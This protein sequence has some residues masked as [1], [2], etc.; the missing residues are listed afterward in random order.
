MDIYTSLI[1]SLSELRNFLSSLPDDKSLYLDLE[2]SN[3]GRHGSISLLTV[4]V[5]P[6]NQV[7]LI[8]LLTLGS[9]AFTTSSAGGATLKSILGDPEVPKYFWDLRNDADA[10]WSLFNV[11]LANVTD[12]QLLENASRGSRDNT[13]LSGLDTAVRLDLPQLRPAERQRWARTKQAVK[14]RMPAAQVFSAWP[15]DAETVEY[16]VNDVRYL[17]ALQA[18][19]ER[20]ISPRG[21]AMAKDHSLQR[22]VEVRSPSYDPQSPNKARG[23]WAGSRPGRVENWDILNFENEDELEDLISDWEDDKLC[24]N[25]VDDFDG[26]FDDCWTKY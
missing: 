17:P 11:G 9:A 26:A 22:A 20:R 24:S 7:H 21:L 10:L 8:D 14:A 15:L 23:P 25:D 13:F 3:L 19:Y 6:G 16:C 1:T 12:I 5:H 4:L 18:V 2:G